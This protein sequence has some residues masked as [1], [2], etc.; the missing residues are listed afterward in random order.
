[1][2][3]F[4][5][6]L[7]LQVLSWLEEE[8]KMTI[9]ERIKKTDRG[10]AR[11]IGFQADPTDFF[12]QFQNPGKSYREQFSESTDVKRE[13]SYGNYRI[14]LRTVEPTLE[15]RYQLDVYDARVNPKDPNAPQNLRARKTFEDPRQAI[16]LYE[17]IRREL[18]RL[19]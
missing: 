13:Q 11:L 19:R 4:N 17:S 2:N 1:M 10:T 8:C 18:P 3:L 12:K 16:R 14:V 15:G 5:L 6:K 7:F 9:V